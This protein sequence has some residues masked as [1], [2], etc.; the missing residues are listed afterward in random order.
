MST[1]ARPRHSRKEIRHFADELVRGGWVF[2][3]LDASGHSIWSH[4]RSAATYKLP[5]TPRHFDVQRARRDVA[6][7]LGQRPAGK[8]SGKAKPR[9]ERQDFVL[10]QAKKTAPTRAPMSHPVRCRWC[11]H[12]HDAGKV[13]VL[14]RHLDCSTWR[15][16]GCGAMIDDRPPPMGSA[17][18]VQAQPPAPPRRGPRRLPWEGD[19]QDHYDRGID[20]LMREV[21]GGH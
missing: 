14:G 19:N 18:K 10:A 5:E 7:L 6:K 12:I 17:L 4:S 11:D 21:P 16:P 20:R 8:R 2:E 15:C 1:P 13:R 9:R 3:R